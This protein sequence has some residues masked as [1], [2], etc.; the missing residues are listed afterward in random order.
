MI[1]KVI[2]LTIIVTVTAF[3][4]GFGGHK[5]GRGGHHGGFNPFKG[6]E[7]NLTNEQRDQVRAVFNNTELTKG[8]QEQELSQLFQSFGLGDQVSF[9]LLSFYEY[10]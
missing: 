4:G 7:R 8:Q 5:G 1:G 6:L 9:I 3:H 2:L 10:C